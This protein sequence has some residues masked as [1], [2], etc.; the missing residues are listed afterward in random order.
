MREASA[1]D[2]GRGRSRRSL[3]DS[4]SRLAPFWEELVE[5]FRYRDLI[6]Q[7]VSRDVK[8]RYKRSILGVAWTMLNPLLMMTILTI[9]F[10]NLFRVGLPHY[11]LYVL[12]G[13]VLWNFF[14]QTTTAAS[15]VMRTGGSLLDKVYVPRTIFA[16]S[17]VGAGLVNLLIALMPLVA[18]GLITGEP[19]NGSFLW[20]SVA[21]VLTTAFA[22]GVG[23]LVC[24]IAIPFPDVVEMWETLL[25]AWYFL[26]PIIYPEQM[27]S[28][29]F[30]SW[31]FVNPMYHLVLLFRSPLHEGVG[32][33]PEHLVAATLFAVGTL[34]LGWYVFASRADEISAR[35]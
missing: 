31:L 9:V 12:A 16:L 3:Y 33:T 1:V 34:V 19:P 24:T 28:D 21:I 17:A 30:R 15:N 18:I 6:Q 32:P 7:L 5:A 4:A 27:L 2:E 23:L 10:S 14:A 25:I 29:D 22:L 8:A 11:A 13:I 35:L 26:T 20:L